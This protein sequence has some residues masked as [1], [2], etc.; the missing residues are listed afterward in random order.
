MGKKSLLSPNGQWIKI[1]LVNF[2]LQSNFS[3][4]SK[5]HTHT[6]THKIPVVYLIFLLPTLTHHYYELLSRRNLIKTLLKHT[7]KIYE[8]LQKCNL[9]WNGSSGDIFRILLHVALSS[10]FLQPFNYL[11]LAISTPLSAY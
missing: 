3:N 4:K 7:N 10:W 11:M 5:T 6:H 8:H 1:V 9:C 2:P